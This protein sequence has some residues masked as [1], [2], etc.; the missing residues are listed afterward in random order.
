MFSEWVHNFSL[1]V[2][3]MYGDEE[4]P[5][6]PPTYD[7]LRQKFEAGLSEQGALTELAGEWVEVEE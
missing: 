7:E 5:F 2:E 1:L 6:E 4:L 3:D